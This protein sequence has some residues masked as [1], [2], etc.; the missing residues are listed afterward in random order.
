MDG[1][2]ICVRDRFLPASRRRRRVVGFLSLC[3]KGILPEAADSLSLLCLMLFRVLSVRL[4]TPDRT[5]GD[6]QDF[7]RSKELFSRFWSIQ[8]NPSATRW[9]GLLPFRNSIR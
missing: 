3:A 2:A 1:G 7:S 6:V 4:K 9:Q 5:S 8:P